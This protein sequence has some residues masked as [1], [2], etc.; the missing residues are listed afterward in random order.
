MRKKLFYL[1]CL[2]DFLQVLST[3]IGEE[4]EQNS[5]SNAFEDDPEALPKHVKWRQLLHVF[6]FSFFNSLDFALPT[7]AIYIVECAELLPPRHNCSENFPT[8]PEMVGI[9]LRRQMR[10]K[11]RKFLLRG[12]K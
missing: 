1:A 9:D 5:H 4:K 10:N 12:T 6:I 7:C 2:G 11:Q 8:W 3:L